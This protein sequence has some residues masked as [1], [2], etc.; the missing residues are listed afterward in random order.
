M[1]FREFKV[2]ISKQFDKMNKHE[3]FRLNVEK[4]L[5]WELYLKSFPEGTNPMFREK[6]EHDC[7]CCKQ[8]IRA[9]GGMVAIIEGKIV[10]VWDVE[11]G[12]FYQVVADALSSYVKSFPIDNIFL[13]TEPTAGTDKNYEMKE[14]KTATWEHFYIK[15]PPNRVVKGID[16]GPRLSESRALHD[17]FI[18]SLSEITDES[19]ETVIELIGQNSLYRGEEKLSAVKA[20]QKL[21]MEFNKLQNIAEKDIFCWSKIN[22][23]PPSISK[24]RNDVIGSLLVDL[25]EGKD[26]DKAVASF[27]SKVAPANY[28]RPTALITKAMIELAKQ[29]I[30]ELGLSSALERRYAKIQ[31]ITINNVLFA[32]RGVKS[33]MSGD[34][35]AQLIKQ[36][37]EKVPNSDKIDEVSI[38]TFIKNILPTAD[39]IELMFENKHSG[40]LVSLVAPVDP[41]AQGMFKWPNNFSWSYTG[42]M[43]DSIKERV[44][45]AGGNVTGDLCLRLGWFNYDDLDAHMKEP[46]GY[47]IYFVNRNNTS[48]SGGR[49][50]VDMNAGGLR[51]REAVENIFYQN[52]SKMKEGRYKYQVHNFCKRETIDDGFEVEMDYLGNVTRFVYP[53]PVPGGKTIDVVEYEYSHKNGVVIIKALPA[54]QAVKNIWGLSTQSFHKVSV[55][56]NSPNYWDEKAVGNKHYFFMLENCLN[57]GKARG[58]FNEFLKEELNVHRKVLEVVGAKMKTDE[59]QDQLSGL[60]FSSTQRNSILCR[61]K[62]NFTRTIKITF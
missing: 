36:A 12:G 38:E 25:S 54:S 24:M 53:N 8:F 27:E 9:V 13:H 21:K 5:L 6:T 40:N 23:I 15:L 17:V 47:E 49:L 14:G 33:N 50:D 51:S 19:V 42:E 45:S 44:K 11:V 41:S 3:L 48:P 20:F 57:D 2:A 31:D 59:S 43:T 52:R 37:P 34:V 62:G 26:L 60:G 18:R 58:F 46:G 55:I 35:F 22:N 4:D 10:S 32:D 56:M 1:E 7:N 30:E 28:K 29:K 39:S 61:V 16:I